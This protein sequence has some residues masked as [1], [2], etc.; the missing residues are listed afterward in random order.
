MFN[1][2]LKDAI[3]KYPNLKIHQDSAGNSF[4]KGILDIPNDRNEIVGNFLVEVRICEKFPFRF[5]ILYEIGGVIPNTADYH[6]Y[7][8][9]SCCITVLADEILKCRNG[10]V[11]PLFIEKYAVP[12]FANFLHRKQIGKYKNGEFAHGLE[13]I[14][15][16]YRSLM[17]TDNQ[18]LW[19]QFY[20]NT[21]RNLK[22]ESG[23]NDPC[24]CGS[25]SKHKHCH[26][27]V[28]NNLRIIG[29]EQIQKDFN[30]IFK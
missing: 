20:K 24:F 23:R 22:I 12:Y 14:I 16:F 11:V 6:K 4:L 15:Q 3:R 2:Q 21:F 26:L 29:E 18:D 1:N 28:F 8:D 5:P 30:L 10:I 27:E 19:I 9:S 7:T 25:G 17:K 13:G